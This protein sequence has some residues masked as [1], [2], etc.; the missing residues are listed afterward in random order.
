VDVWLDSVG[1]GTI[2]KDVANAEVFSLVDLANMDHAE[3][4]AALPN[5]DP[6]VRNLLV[7]KLEGATL[8]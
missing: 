6:K 7:S 2:K 1:L 4:R 3:I 5:T 8:D